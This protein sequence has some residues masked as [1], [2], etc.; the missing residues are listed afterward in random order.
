MKQKITWLIIVI[1][2]IL[3]FFC[4]NDIVFLFAPKE[5]VTKE[6][7]FADYQNLS[8]AYSR[9][10]DLAISTNNLWETVKCTGWAFV[11]TD[12]P[13]EGKKGN[14]I[15]KGTKNSYI[16]TELTFRT[17]TIAQEA[18][19]WKQ[20]GD[21][22]N[23][24][25]VEFSTVN[26]PSDDYEIYVYLEENANAI[27]LVDTGIG[28]R[29][30]GVNIESYTVVTPSEIPV[31]DEMTTMFDAGWWD[32]YPQASYMSVQGWQIKTGIAS[33]NLNYHIVFW[34]DNG[35]TVSFKLPVVNHFSLG[36]EYGQEYIS[37][38]FQGSIDYD[39]LPDTVGMISIVAENNGTWYCA[40]PIPYAL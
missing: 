14:L 11:E 36:T 7:D 37:S 28:F 30:N 32:F 26:L 38:G 2:V 5:L 24:F 15:L 20:T 12:A 6:V 25:T 27:G 16:T 8:K 1:A 23:R 17:S 22:N 9:T 31:P 3:V 13:T 29:K 19:G 18:P 4:L 10:D 35:K 34:G 40:E 33:E 21:T 39:L